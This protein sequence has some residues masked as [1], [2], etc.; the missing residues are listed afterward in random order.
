MGRPV[1]PL[2]AVVLLLA[3]ALGYSLLTSQSRAKT[4]TSIVTVTRQPP[5]DFANAFAQHLFVFS[6][7]NVSAIVSQYTLTANVTWNGLM[8]WDGLYPD[9]GNNSGQYADLLG[10]VFDESHNPFAATGLHSVFVGNMTNVSVTQTGEGTV[11]NATF[12][13]VAEATEG[14]F[15]ATVSAQDTYVY[16]AAAGWLIS[17]ELWHF[18]NYYVPPT[19]LVCSV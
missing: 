14:N 17:G 3:S 6:S 15:A 11:V 2:L 16:S 19:T 9:A 13:L 4:V 7:R 5:E 1:I 8:C 18:L 10:I 12:G